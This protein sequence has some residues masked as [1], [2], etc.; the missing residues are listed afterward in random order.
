MN[1]R[2]SGKEGT[3]LLMS[4]Y[5]PSL[6]LCSEKW[7]TGLWRR[8]TG[9]NIKQLTLRV[10]RPCFAERSWT[11]AASWMSDFPVRQGC[12]LRMKTKRALC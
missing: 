7:V 6:T 2:L 9:L 10:R 3:H 5:D 4:G 11:K 8:A 1:Q 12:V